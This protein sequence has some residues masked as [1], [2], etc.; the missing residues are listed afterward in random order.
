MPS[1]SAAAALRV[2]GAARH[3]LRR[4][5]ARQGPAGR[6]DGRLR[7]HHRRQRRRA[8]STPASP[9]GR[10]RSR[11]WP[12]AATLG[13]RRRDLVRRAD[14]GDR[15][16]TDFAGFAA[17]TVAAAEAVSPA[18]DAVASAWERSASPPRRPG[19]PG[20]DHGPAATPTVVTRGPVRRVR[21]RPAERGDGARRRPA[22]PRGRVADRPDRLPRRDRRAA[23][24]PTGSSTPSRCAASRSS[25]AS[26]TSPPSCSG[27]P[28][29]LLE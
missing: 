24:S 18:A 12:S 14:L 7:R 27:W 29:L 3:G 1:A 4:P 22:D 11:P 21:R 15:A 5:G 10:S 23:R 19:R 17:A 25:S 28:R 9:T 26:R 16:D 2:D 20:L 13:R 8:H 6:A